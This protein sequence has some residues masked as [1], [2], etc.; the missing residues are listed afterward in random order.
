MTS[1]RHRW[2]LDCLIGLMRPLEPKSYLEVGARN[3]VSLNRIGHCMLPTGS[4]IVV[5]D[6]PEGPWGAGE[7]RSSLMKICKELGEIH[8]VKLFL[9]DSHQDHIVEQVREHGPFDLG[10]IDGDHT[11]D[12]VKKDWENYG[13][14]CNTV[15][16]DDIFSKDITYTDKD[17]ESMD[18][19][20]PQLWRSIINN[21]NTVEIGAKENHER[22]PE[23]GIGVIF[24]Q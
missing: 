17:G 9:A 11:Y 13:P 23:Q 16:F 14:M 3:G 5:I 24:L 21:R 7:D 4:K 2:E 6:M 12:G 10:Y 19:G 18:S 8:D 15:A 20:V 1:K 22:N